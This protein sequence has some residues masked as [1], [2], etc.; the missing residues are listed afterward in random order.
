[1][2]V[3]VGIAL[4][5]ISTLVA[6]CIKC[7]HLHYGYFRVIKTKLG[8]ASCKVNMTGFLG[9]HVILVGDS[10]SLATLRGDLAIRCGT[11]KLAKISLNS[12]H[13]E[14]TRLSALLR[15]G[16][17]IDVS[18]FIPLRGVQNNSADVELSLRVETNT[19]PFEVWVGYAVSGTQVPLSKS[20]AFINYEAESKRVEAVSNK[21]V[22]DKFNKK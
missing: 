22:S 12:P 5:F 21:L 8:D 11:N 9:F 6:I 13:E 14:N 10:N 1:M 7:G 17:A 16:Y 3:I 19:A 20:Y 4:I 15:A 2:Y 18:R